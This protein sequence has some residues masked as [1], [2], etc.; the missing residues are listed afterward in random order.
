MS[1]KKNAVLKSTE[2]RSFNQKETM[3]WL[4]ANPLWLITWGARNFTRYED[5]ALF[6]TVSG[7][8]H[9]GI[10]LITLAWDDTYT[11]RLLSTQWNEKAKF[12]N[13]YCDELAEIIDINIE[14]I[15]DYIR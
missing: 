1:A 13:V 15:E 8:K 2:E 3:Q 7:N 11:V 6:F 12:E 9:K 5:K 14:R 10:V 4:K